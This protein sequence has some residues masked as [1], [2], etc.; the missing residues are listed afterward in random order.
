MTTRGSALHRLN[1]M[2][3]LFTQS[4]DRR[5]EAG[6]VDALAAFDAALP[7]AQRAKIRDRMVDVYQRSAF[8]PRQKDRFR[9]LL[10]DSGFAAAV[11]DG[12]GA[13]TSEGLAKL[14]RRA[15]LERLSDDAEVGDEIE[16]E[17]LKEP[18]R[19]KMVAA[20]EDLEAEILERRE[21]GDVQLS[22]RPLSMKSAS[23]E[24]VHVGYVVEAEVTGE[25]GSTTEHHYFTARGALVGAT[26]LEPVD[27]LDW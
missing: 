19:T 26:G 11:L 25:G 2:H 9:S 5:L 1:G 20:L 23:G 3:R 13:G 24:R 12:K 17:D 22:L 18:L 14:S 4:G 7:R 6:E 21:Y 10:R 8:A 16:A 27:L 15:Q